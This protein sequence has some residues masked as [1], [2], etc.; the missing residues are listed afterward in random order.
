MQGPAAAVMRGLPLAEPWHWARE[1]AA[2]SPAW[3]GTRR[4]APVKQIAAWR[5][6]DHLSEE[7]VKAIKSYIQKR[8]LEDRA[9][10]EVTN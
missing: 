5:F 9:R 2:L 10:Q 1:R 7:D 4:P 3:V 6:A 8:A